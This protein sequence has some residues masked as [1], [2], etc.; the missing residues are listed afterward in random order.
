MDC[1]DIERK[2]RAAMKLQGTYSKSMEITISLAAGP[3]FAYMKARNAVEDLDKD[4]CEIRTS[5]EGNL[6]KV[7]HPEYKL[8]LDMAEMVR[9]YL[10][11]LRL[12]RATIEG[13]VDDDDV[14]RLVRDVENAGK[15]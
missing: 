12:T 7:V 3:L 5:R 11:E 6:Y 8:M 2:I 9:K 13:F 1:K 15:E 4:C 14:D 10:R